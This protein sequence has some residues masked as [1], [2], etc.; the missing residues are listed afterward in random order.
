MQ[1]RPNLKATP[2]LAAVVA[3]LSGLSGC[4]GQATPQP[5]AAPAETAPSTPAD[6]GQ[7]TSQ[8][9][10]PGD[11][12]SRPGFFEN[13]TQ[14]IGHH[15]SARQPDG[16]G[17][18]SSRPQPVYR[19]SDNRPTHDDRALAAFGVHLYQSKR[20]KLYTDIDP[21]IAQK[22]PPLIDAAYVA[23]E[24]YF[25]KLPPNREGTPFQ[26]TGYLMADK[27]L[28][29]SAA[30]VPD[31]LRPF[32]NGRHRGAEF[33]MNDQKYNYYRR[34]LVIHESTH[35]FME[36][37]AGERYYE[38]LPVWYWEG[39]A[40]LFGTHRIGPDGTV[41]F[42]VMP[43]DRETFAG[44][45]R[46]TMIRDAVQAGRY[47]SRHDVTRLRAEAYLKPQAYAW[48]WWLCYFL[49]AHSRYRDSF[50]K[51]G[52][53]LTG[54]RFQAA[55]REMFESQK[56]S[57]S[58][59]WPLFVHNLQY[60]YD[61][62]RASIDFQAGHALKPPPQQNVVEIAA[63]RGWQSSGFLLQKGVTYEVTATGE[64]TLAR[65]PNPWISQ[66]QGISFDY[67][68]GRPLGMLLAAVRV[69]KPESAEQRTSMLDVVP[70]G[71]QRRFVSRWS[72]TLYF[73]L[74]D[75]WSRL[76]DNSGSVR[77]FVRRSAE[78]DR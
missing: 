16:P 78:T 44:L 47:K 28:F 38:E 26:M 20:L 4:G 13:T 18:G 22:L 42:R 58:T 72:G 64:F 23:W 66:P 54:L 24:A 69:E 1:Q 70:I 43:D 46:I 11:A 67:F 41:H 65:K 14:N 56:P 62:Q 25:G 50:H 45:A 76:A 49:D 52:G 39:M 15:N 32:F 73:R 51:L 34:H 74:N 48:S 6:P 12:V 5:Q 57:L 21:K 68:N 17:D 31:D 55:A 35:C 71:R 9:N 40:E 37:I 10:A 8:N 59:E 75:S 60:G 63:D 53:F 33:W 77:V 2:L 29:R 3:M 7:R 30:L 27:E 19:L 36:A 61:L